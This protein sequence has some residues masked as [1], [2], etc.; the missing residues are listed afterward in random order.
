MDRNQIKFVVDDS[1]VLKDRLADFPHSKFLL[2]SKLLVFGEVNN[3]ASIAVCGIRSS[4]NVLSVHVKEGFRAQRVGRRI[5]QETLNLARK[6]SLSFVTLTVSVDNVPAMRLFSRV[7]FRKI[8]YLKKRGLMVMMLPII[9]K[10][11]SLFA[12]WRVVGSMLPDKLMTR[13][14]LWLGKES[15]EREQRRMVTES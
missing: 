5:L 12:F 9:L 13:V 14:Y 15:L 11:K 4:M 3:N 1:K 2:P 8:A 10:G 6:K 7:G